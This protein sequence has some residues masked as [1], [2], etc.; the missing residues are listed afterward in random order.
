M[1]IRQFWNRA[2]ERLFTN[3]TLSNLSHF[4]LKC[5][6]I[7]LCFVCYS[8]SDFCFNIFVVQVLN[9]KRSRKAPT[10]YGKGSD[11]VNKDDLFDCTSDD[12]VDDDDSVE[13]VENENRPIKKRTRSGDTK[14]STKQADRSETAPQ[15]QISRLEAKLDI[16]IQMIQKMQRSIISLAIDPTNAGKC[17]GNFDFFRNFPLKTKESMDKLEEDLNDH[18]FRQMLVSFSYFSDSFL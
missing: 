3:G 18:E 5:D 10:R 2:V 7:G 13:V 4:K 1:L 12:S 6:S 11:S 17:N 15:T 14:S 16:V 8:K 9:G